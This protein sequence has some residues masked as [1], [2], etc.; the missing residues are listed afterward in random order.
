M[1]L[2]VGLSDFQSLVKEDYIFADK[3]LF[4]KEIMDDGAKII[5]IPRPR[6]FGKTLNLSMLSYFFKIDTDHTLFD[7]LLI[8]KDASFCTKHQN[9]YPVIFVS[10]KDIKESSYLGAYKEIRL[11]IS[12]LYSE[13][14]YLLEGDVLTD[15][16]KRTFTQ[17]INKEAEPEEIKD[18]LKQLTIFTAR[19]FGKNPVLLIDEY[20][21]PI[22]EAYLRGYYSEM[23]DIMRGMLGKVLK[24]NIYLTKAVLTGITRV[25]QESMFSG[26]N[27]VEVYSLLREEYGQYF[28]FTEEEVVKLIK[29]TKQEI[30]LEPIKE[31]Y[32]GYQ[33][34][35]YVLYNPW[36]II[37][38]LKNHGKLQPYWLNTSSNDLIAKLLT[39]AN[40]EI[41][42]QFEEL[43]QGNIIERALAENL[44]FMDIE[45]REDALWSL[46]LYAGYLKVLSSEL[47][48]YNLI[49]RMSIPNKEVSFV[50]AR[51]VREWFSSAI[52]IDAYSRFVES[53]ASS[54]MEKFK[55]YISTYIIQSGSYFDFN[56][57][58]PE[59]IFHIFILGLVVGMRDRYVL[60]SNKESGFGRY[61]V[62]FIPKKLDLA[63]IILEFK[64]AK[65]PELLRER[66]NDA[67]VQI[68]DMEYMSIFKSHNVK[69]V[70]AIGMSFCGKEM[71]MIHEVIDLL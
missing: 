31:W 3:S 25:S 51:I 52:S 4:I 21:T 29:D 6:R 42:H 14:R 43:L 66:A 40:I 46:L 53:L 59:Q 56:H 13:H 54:N 41:K 58:T 26:L 48:D 45:K 19:K 24:D 65:T 11:L 30:D 18:S 27:N 71:D 9:Q 60:S 16:E 44:V 55:L 50:Y 39:N 67:L 22:Q 33:V 12:G 10:F 15:D 62:M 28:G 35:K 49:A 8:S 64:V 1:R 63:G 2:P 38:C 37:N 34:G 20:D 47:V 17:I 23:I 69:S 32:N 68:K 36:S 70:L 5:L 7:N 61:D 57:N